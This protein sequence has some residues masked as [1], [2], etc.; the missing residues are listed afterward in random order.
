MIAFPQDAV[1]LDLGS[2]LGVYSLLVAQLRHSSGDGRPG[3]VVAVDAQADNLAFIS[4]SL[5]KNNIP[6]QMITLVHNA[7]SDV[8]EPLYPIRMGNDPK[9]N[10]G[11]WQFVSKVEVNEE[12][13]GEVLGRPTVSITMAS[14]LSSLPHSTYIVK[15][16]I[17]GMECKA[18][19]SLGA[20]P[21]AIMPYI[22]MEWNE[23]ADSPKRCPNIDGLIHQLESE[24]YIARWPSPLALM[25]KHCLYAP[26]INVLWVHK[27]AR[28]IWNTDWAMDCEVY[29]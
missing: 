6:Q 21:A 12:E 13:E 28:P 26:P 5:V 15:M 16:D 4:H 19:R 3:R 7:I 10:P 11:S 8:S 1:F 9:D 27:S 23:I 24:G 29:H 18:L 20:F 22:F 2:N 25:P 17:Q 14:L